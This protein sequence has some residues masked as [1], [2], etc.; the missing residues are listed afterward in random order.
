[1]LKK[2]RR[3]SESFAQIFSLGALENVNYS[4][5]KHCADELANSPICHLKKCMKL[6]KEN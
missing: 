5:S 1:M 3:N 4:T 2:I 6:S